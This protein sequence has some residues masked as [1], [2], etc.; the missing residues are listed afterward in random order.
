MKKFRFRLEKVL[1]YRRIVKDEKLRALL[2][3]NAALDEATFMLAALEDEAN[4]PRIAEGQ[5]LTVDQL[6]ALDHYN[7]RL[8]RSIEEQR[9]RIK[10]L[11]AAA[12]QALERYLEAAKD[13]KALAMLKDKKRISYM[14]DVEREM[15]HVLDEVAMQMSIRSGD[16]EIPEM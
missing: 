2:E 1:T 10:E 4:R 15:Q 9:T 6:I 12:A 11:H 16:V 3:A 14:E 8:A 7:R 5:T 13:E